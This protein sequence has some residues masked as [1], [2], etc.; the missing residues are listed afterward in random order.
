[1]K[2]SH[3]QT[4]TNI[5]FLHDFYVNLQFILISWA[6]CRYISLASAKNQEVCSDHDSVTKSLNH[7]KRENE[8]ALK[9]RKLLEHEM[10]V[11]EERKQGTIKILSQIGKDTAITEQQIKVVKAQL[12]RISR[13]KKVGKVQC[14]IFSSCIRKLQYNYIL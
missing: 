12:D 4:H 13:L 9:L 1:M 3:L 10:I 8:V 2:I 7:I 6:F 11:L 5:K 14:T